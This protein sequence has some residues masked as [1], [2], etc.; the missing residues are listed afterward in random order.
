MTQHCPYCGEQ[1][2]PDEIIDCDEQPFRMNVS[3]EN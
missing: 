3:T 2:E 1:K